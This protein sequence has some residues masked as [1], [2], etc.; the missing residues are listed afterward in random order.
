MRQNIKPSYVIG[1]FS[2]LFFLIGVLLMAV[3]PTFNGHL[4]VVINSIGVS[5]PDTWLFMTYLG[6]GRFIGCVLIIFFW[7]RAHYLFVSILSGIS[8]HFIVQSAKRLLGILRPEHNTEGI[9]VFALGPSLNVTDYAF[10]SGHS[11]ASAMCACLL[12]LTIPSLVVRS[13]LAVAM[14]CVAL[15][16]VA[17]AAHWPAD[18]FAGISLGSIIAVF[19]MYFSHHFTSKVIAHIAYFM[20]FALSLRVIF[21]QSS[22]YSVLLALSY[23]DLILGVV[24]SSLCVL[25][26]F[27]YTLE[28]GSRLP[29]F[30]KKDTRQQ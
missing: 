2:C 18:I 15:S 7:R 10:P 22:M 13:L 6:D 17:I 14:F 29:F 11:A 19:W 26:Y 30:M 12:I 1:L 4:L 20:C 5:M 23:L 28:V 27:K 16:R 9:E 24:A 21:S 25:G 3:L 8:V